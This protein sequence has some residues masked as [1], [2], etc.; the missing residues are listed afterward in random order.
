MVQEPLAVYYIRSGEQTL[1]D[2][3]A[4]Y[5]NVRDG[6]L[7]KDPCFY[8]LWQC[9]DRVMRQIVC[10]MSLYPFCCNQARANALYYRL[11]RS[12]LLRQEQGI[13]GC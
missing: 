12:A 8:D 2:V 1:Y 9:Q 10:L 6:F 13:A 11:T 3:V 5:T 7:M 4:W